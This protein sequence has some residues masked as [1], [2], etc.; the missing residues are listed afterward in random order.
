MLPALRD[1]FSLA[2][3]TLAS[4]VFTTI[5]VIQS[6]RQGQ[7]SVPITYDDIVY[8]VDAAYR[9]QLFYDS[10]IGPFLRS[11][12]AE[13]SHAPLSTVMALLGFAVFGINDWAPAV[14][15]AVWV[16]I[17]LLFVR[18]LLWHLPRWAFVAISLSVLSWPLVGSLVIDV[19]PDMVAGLLTVIGCCLMIRSNF[20]GS[21]ARHA[22]F[23]SVPFGLALIAKPSISPVTFAIF[24]L[25]LLV[26]V[27]VDGW[28]NFD[29]RFL[30]N[31]ARQI[32]KSCLVILLI[33]LPYFATAWRYVY[34]Y[35]FRT[36]FGSEKQIWGIQMDVVD[37][38]AYY[39]WGTGGQT[40]MGAWF[41]VTVV[42]TVLA[43][44]F[45]LANKRVAWR[46][47]GLLAVFLAAY[48]MVSIPAHKS[49]FLGVIVPTFWLAF[50]V[51]ACGRIVETLL[52]ASR[53]G[54]LSSQ[55]YRQHLDV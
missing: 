37:A 6:L 31:A 11:C 39:L 55:Q 23:V 43:A 36:T 28:P 45:D 34:E 20:V 13:P 9:L 4:F 5:V 29:R 26:T 17:L 41:W 54:L 15:N 48:G 14:A 38:A 42:L 22:V 1:S 2:Y 46:N 24:G 53:A 3:A 47:L 51:L 12:F 33:A 50:Y 27:I 49:P 25:S 19:R 8:F 10:G 21:S 30:R 18:G 35:I 7:L 40:M 44:V 52:H 16:A 32:V